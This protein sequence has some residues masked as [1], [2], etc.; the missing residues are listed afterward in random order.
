MLREVCHVVKWL[1]ILVSIYHNI[2]WPIREKLALR[3]S[4]TLCL[5]LC[6]GELV[7]VSQSVLVIWKY[8]FEFY[9][10]KMATLRDYEWYTT[11]LKKKVLNKMIIWTTW[12]Y[13]LIF[14]YSSIVWPGF[15]N[16]HNIRK[17]KKA[18]TNSMQNCKT[19]MV[20]NMKTDFS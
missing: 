13:L 4:I 16:I 1:S 14:N 15:T 11:V 17:I 12:K 20:M 2:W 18:R 3:I 6:T 8:Y 5:P 7:M 10:K 9:G 19:S